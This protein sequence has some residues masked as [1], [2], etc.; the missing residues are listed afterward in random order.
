[1]RL[2]A[3]VQV[4]LHA[5]A[6]AGCPGQKV[7]AALKLNTKTHHLQELQR[8]TKAFEAEVKR[9]LQN[10]SELVTLPITQP[11]CIYALLPPHARG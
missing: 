3:L 11:L 8:S 1:M 4:C 9:R 2:F 10:S 5:V 7:F 6:K